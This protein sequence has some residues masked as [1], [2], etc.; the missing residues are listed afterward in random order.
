M[1]FPDKPPTIVLFCL[2][3]ESV[4]QIGICRREIHFCHRKFL[5][6]T[7]NEQFQSFSFLKI[8]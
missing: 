7:Q 3:N 4:F 1:L 2:L 8:F 5:K 6:S